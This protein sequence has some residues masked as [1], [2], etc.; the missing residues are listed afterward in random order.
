MCKPQMALQLT[1]CIATMK[2]YN[3][4][5]SSLPQYLEM[6]CVSKVIV[7]DE[8]GDDVRAIKRQPWASNPKLELHVNL[9]R[10]GAL[11][12]KA[13]CMSL[14]KGWC[15]L[16][17]SDNFAPYDTYFVPWIT[18]MAA[19]AHAD[20][21]RF[22]FAPGAWTDDSGKTVINMS[23]YSQL[24]MTNVGTAVQR[25]KLAMQILND[26]NFIV[27]AS[28]YNTAFTNPQLNE[29][30][31]KYPFTAWDA[32]LKI[33]QLLKRGAVVKIMK[34]MTYI[35]A[36]HDG[37]MFATEGESHENHVVCNSLKQ[38]ASIEETAFMKSNPTRRATPLL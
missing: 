33:M 8:T 30:A 20:I 11:G 15:A 18:F 10:L 19:W 16:L 5:K 12:N 27:H 3:F 2:R 32:A 6:P 38:F 13:K 7:C 35:H 17:D 9:T 23:Q 24:D 29:L 26:G 34:R 22:I 1:V 14:A 25:S 21:H 37:S 4:L 36:V 28:L 31:A